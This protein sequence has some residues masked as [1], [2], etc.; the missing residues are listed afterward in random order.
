MQSNWKSLESHKNC[1]F[2]GAIPASLG[3]LT[4]VTQVFLQSNN[5]TGQIPSSLS[6]LKDLTH[7]D[8]SY[9]NFEG[10]IPD[11]FTNLTLQNSPKLTCLITNSLVKLVNAK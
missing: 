10:R 1:Y 6:N 11:F 4:K 5:L 3:N 2:A 9:N 8:L 7:I